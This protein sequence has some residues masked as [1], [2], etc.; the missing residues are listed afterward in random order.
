MTMTALLL[1]L[2]NNWKSI[3]SVIA[4]LLILLAINMYLDHVFETGKEEGIA[5]TTKTWKAKYDKDIKTL[6][7]KIAETEQTSRHNAEV[8]KLELETAN[9]KITDLQLMIAKQR[10]KYDRIIYDQRGKKVCETTEA[11]YLGPDFSA[12][13]N[14]LNHEAIQ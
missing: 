1:F 11:I 13:W 7:D 10:D 2:K 4:V 3:A 5:E 8:A 9:T 12:E 14:K 6:N